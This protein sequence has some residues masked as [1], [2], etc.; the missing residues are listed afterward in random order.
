MAE[1]VEALL[2]IPFQERL[3]GIILGAGTGALELEVLL[4]PGHYSPVHQLICE[5]SQ[6]DCQQDGSQPVRRRLHT[7][8]ELASIHNPDCAHE[9]GDCSSLKAIIVIGGNPNT[10]LSIYH[11]AKKSHAVNTLSVYLTLG[12]TPA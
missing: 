9:A 1:G 5:Q 10:S 3:R 6:Q 4:P 2:G 12:G 11:P 8:L 7:P